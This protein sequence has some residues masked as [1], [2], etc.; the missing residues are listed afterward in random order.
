VNNRC[1]RCGGM[2]ERHQ[3][4]CSRGRAFMAES[5]SLVRHRNWLRLERATALSANNEF[6][7]EVLA[8]EL[9]DEESVEQDRTGTGR[10]CT[11]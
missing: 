5:L 9:A 2:F 8:S 3:R 4:N 1:A 7:A 6:A 10:K 11:A